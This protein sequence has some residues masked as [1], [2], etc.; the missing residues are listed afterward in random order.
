VSPSR[1]AR[2]KASI[3]S[4]VSPV[5]SSLAGAVGLLSTSVIV[6]SSSADGSVCAKRG[7][8]ENTISRRI[9]PARVERVM[10]RLLE[11]IIE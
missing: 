6:P 9:K 1:G 7:G 8:A 4:G 10:W 11:C 3:S 2:I 5:D